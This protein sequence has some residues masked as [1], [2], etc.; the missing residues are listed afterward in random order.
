MIVISES[1][2][3]KKIRMSM[4]ATNS[5]ELESFQLPDIVLAQ[6][7]VKYIDS[8]R[9]MISRAYLSIDWTLI[10]WILMMGKKVGENSSTRQFH[11]DINY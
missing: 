1:V 6:S 2:S 9:R 7:N 11:V 3:M 10:I 8:S 4:I 5:C